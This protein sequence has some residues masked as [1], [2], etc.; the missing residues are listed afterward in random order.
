MGWKKTL[1]IIVSLATIFGVAFAVFAYYDSRKPIIEYYMSAPLYVD[2]MVEHFLTANL[3]ANNRGGTDCYVNLHVS[4]INAT[5]VNAT[6]PGLTFQE[7]QDSIQNNGTYVTILGRL[8]RKETSTYED[9]ADVDI[10]PLSGTPRF[11]V[12][13]TIDIPFSFA[14]PLSGD[15]IHLVLADLAY[16]KT[17]NGDYSKIS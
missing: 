5:I 15:K 2:M 9:I 3:M 13:Y 4:V 10:Q 12:Y 1:G 14:Y 7:A 17:Q 11:E 8:V 16:N 6:I